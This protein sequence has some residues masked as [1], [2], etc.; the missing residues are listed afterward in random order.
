MFLE[1]SWPYTSARISGSLCWWSSL[2]NLKWRLTC[3]DGAHSAWG[4]RNRKSRSA[5]P[6]HK[7]RRSW[8]WIWYFRHYSHLRCSVN[9]KRTGSCECYRMQKSLYLVFS[10]FLKVGNGP[11]YLRS[12]KYRPCRMGLTYFLMKPIMNLSLR[13]WCIMQSILIHY[14]DRLSLTL[15]R[16]RSQNAADEWSN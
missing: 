4:F 10:R 2:F 6:A 13:R 16:Q 9:Y 5:S 14:D 15:K 8:W 12:V 7:R 1:S 11:I 3:Y